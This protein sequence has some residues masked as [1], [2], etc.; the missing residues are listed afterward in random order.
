MVIVKGKD[1]VEVSYTG[2]VKET[3]Q[4]FDL[5]DEET[6]KKEKLFNPKAEY[7]SK[8][9]CI[10]EHQI[11]KELDHQLIEKEVG[12][13][14][15]IELSPEKA[16][17]NK[18]P[19]LVKIV[20]TS[21][22]HEQKIRPF[23]GLQINASG[24][25]GTIRTVNGGRTTIDFNHPLAGKNIIYNIKINRVITD[26]KEKVEGLTNNLLGLRKKEFEIKLDG[27]EAEIKLNKNKLAEN[28]KE[29]FKRKVKDLVSLDVTFN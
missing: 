21:V 17:G 1:F 24:L 2:K 11:L 20:P 13:E 26:N 22:L 4:I 16:F 3:D 27:N 6:A 23:P 5:T 15:T 28:I 7:G 18:D 29:E 10:G 8:I 25:I 9:I 14:Y 12:K 19:N